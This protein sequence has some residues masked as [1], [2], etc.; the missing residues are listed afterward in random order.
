M[1]YQNLENE[2]I[3]L[4][5]SLKQYIDLDQLC[6]KTWDLLSEVPFNDKN[7]ICLQ[8]NG[9]DDWYKCSDSFYVSKDLSHFNEMHPKLKGTWWEEFIHTLPYKVNKT[10]ITKVSPKSCSS[11]H[12]NGYKSLHVALYTN[13][14]AHLL[15]INEQRL[16]HIPANGEL[17]YVDT[18]RLHI[19]FNG[20]DDARLHLIMYVND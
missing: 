6:I 15:F 7:Q 13:P 10:C 19:E 1:P 2:S 16:I 12:K 3:F 20:G 11:I 14:G 17:W 5:R 8:T 18:K 9:S 4:F